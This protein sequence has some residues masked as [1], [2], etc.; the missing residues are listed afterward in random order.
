[1]AKRVVVELV[2]DITG[3]PGAVTTSFGIDGVDYEIDLTDDTELRD[4]F[5][6]WIAK[7]RRVNGSGSAARGN[8]Y[9]QHRHEMHRIRQWAR[10]N[11]IKIPARGKIARDTIQA[12][13]AAC[14]LDGAAEVVLKT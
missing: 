13:D 12:Y 11:G 14:K 7:A 4:N 1:M 10:A 6:K 8:G 5:I 2:D 9:G 3:D